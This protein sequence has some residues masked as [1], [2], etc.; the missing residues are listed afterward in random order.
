MYDITARPG[1][2]MQTAT[3]HDMEN[4]TLE[5]RFPI[6][7][8]SEHGGLINMGPGAHYPGTNPHNLH[9]GRGQKFW[10]ATFAN[11]LHAP[12]WR[13]LNSTTTKQPA[14]IKSLCQEVLQA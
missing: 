1:T 11:A 7:S 10:W 3:A 2:G 13:T 6:M 9:P 5:I 4:W 14:V 12:W 8:T